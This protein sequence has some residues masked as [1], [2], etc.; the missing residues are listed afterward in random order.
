[1]LKDGSKVVSSS[2]G[3]QRSSSNEVTEEEGEQKKDP[4]PGADLTSEEDRE[5]LILILILNVSQ[6]QT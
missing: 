1:M 4:L 6:V 3:R 2:K 5:T